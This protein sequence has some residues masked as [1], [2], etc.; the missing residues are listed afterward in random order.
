VFVIEPGDKE[1][2]SNACSR[3]L[4]SPVW[5]QF[6]PIWRTTM[7]TACSENKNR[8]RILPFKWGLLILMKQEI[9]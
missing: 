2:Q 8:T 7:E 9:C 6:P 3:R 4:C 1:T 5:T